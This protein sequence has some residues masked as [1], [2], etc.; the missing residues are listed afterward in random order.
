M[1]KLEDAL[2]EIPTVS[3]PL[4]QLQ[5]IQNWVWANIHFAEDK[6]LFGVPQLTLSAEDT[7]E[8]GFADCEDY[9]NVCY[10]LAL[11]KGIPDD[12]MK[13]MLCTRDEGL[14]HCVMVYM[15]GW[16]VVDNSVRELRSM[17]RRYDLRDYR[18]LDKH[19]FPQH[20]G[21]PDPGLRL[22]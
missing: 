13:L 15:D 7:L 5:H 4:D 9:A 10:R 2:R 12:T 11:A 1:A 16:R 17:Q 21:D 6:D 18:E 22:A 20:A 14:Q 8:I 3:D 19:S